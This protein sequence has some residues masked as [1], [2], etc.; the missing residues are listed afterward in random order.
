MRAL[1]VGLGLPSDAVRAQT[2]LAQ[3]VTALT[4]AR[5]NAS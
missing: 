2:A 4:V 1:K 5:A 3:G